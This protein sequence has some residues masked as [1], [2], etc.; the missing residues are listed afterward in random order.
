MISIDQMKY[1]TSIVEHG[2]LNK[3]AQHLYVSQP[4]LTKQ[5]ALLEKS[6]KCSL[7]LRTPT[8]IKLTPSG[9]YFYERSGAII[10]MLDETIN[11]IESF[12]EGNNI[13]IGGLQNL[14]TYFLPKYVDKFKKMRYEV[15]IEAMDTNAQ[16]VDSLEN[17]FFNLVFISDALQKPEL[18]TIPLLV[19]PFY[20]VMKSSNKLSQMK[21]IDFVTVAKEKLILYKDP[22][23]IRAK[24]RQHCN[25]MNVTPNIILEL[26]L[27]ESLINYVEQDFGIT[28]L[29]KMVIDTI[30]NP[31]ITALEIKKFPIHRVISAVLKKE[32]THSYLS[33]LS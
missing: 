12:G 33:L 8:G 17:D 6:L 1:F 16:L 28:I 22:C 21:D 26:E 29:P 2:S 3:A 24:I 19:E 13:R 5:L 4:A 32:Y 11:E 18:V 9:R 30:N 7:L 14:I 10:K 31:A 20:V 27:T 25:F 23:P 15:S